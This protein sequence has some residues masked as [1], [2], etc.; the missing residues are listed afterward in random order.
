MSDDGTKAVTGIQHG[1]IYT[2]SDSGATWTERPGTGSGYKWW[3][4]AISPDGT[5]IVVA[6]FR[7]SN[8]TEVYISSNFGATWSAQSMAGAW[9]GV[10]ITSGGTAY[11]TD[12]NDDGY[13]YSKVLP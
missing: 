7:Y 8:D 13:V 3:R 6:D 12:T 5:K 2:S 9:S 4:V 11:V 1:N 10:T